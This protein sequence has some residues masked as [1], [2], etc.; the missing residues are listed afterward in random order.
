[1]SQPIPNLQTLPLSL[2]ESDAIPRDRLAETAEAFG[3]L[4]TSI[5]TE[6]LRQPIEV[7]ELAD[8]TPDGAHYGLIAGYRRLAAM[9]S[10]GHDTIPAFIRT[11]NSVAQALAA[12]VSE[13]ETRSQISPWDKARLVVTC[14][15]RDLFPNPDAALDGLYP[16]LSRQKRSRMR[17][18]VLVVDT[19]GTAF[20]TPER[21]TIAQL[22]RL[23]A[24]LRSGWDD[25]LFAAVPLGG[26]SLDSQWAALAP[27]LDEALHPAHPAPNSADAPRR[28]LHLPQCMTIRRELTRTGWI[29]RFSGPDAK[30]PGLVDDVFR[31]VETMLGNR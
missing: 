9:R 14:V 1:M 20:T 24:A 22:D 15:Q 26:A 17:G 12:M 23:A 27:I 19:F 28:M 3:E 30:S 4:V 2:I 11:P 31:L 16:M 18:H 5:L 6:G 8:P 13:N 7:F 21:L 10:L 25:L 29:L